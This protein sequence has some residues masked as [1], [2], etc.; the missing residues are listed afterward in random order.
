LL[1]GLLLGLALLGVSV[2][3]LLEHLESRW[4]WLL[5]LHRSLIIINTV[6]FDIYQTHTRCFLAI[7][8][9]RFWLLRRL[10]F[11]GRHC[12]CSSGILDCIADRGDALPSL[13]PW[14]E[15]E[16]LD[17]WIAPSDIV[18]LLVLG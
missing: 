2:H 14:I 12:L 5:F 16:L 15:K 3:A 7:G 18:P 13:L 11:F 6:F 10:G 9:G 1:L 8:G 17:S 4:L